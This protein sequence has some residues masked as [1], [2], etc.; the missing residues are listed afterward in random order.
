MVCVLVMVLWWVGYLADML[1]AAGCVVARPRL[2]W[3]GAR[4]LDWTSLR[5]T[6]STP[7]PVTLIGGGGHALVVAEAIGQGA[8]LVGFYDDDPAAKL[9]G[10]AQVPCLGSLAEIPAAL[11]PWFM[12]G[13]GDLGLR[14]RVL[15][16]LG[17]ARSFAIT[18]RTAFVSANAAIGTGVFV[19]PHAVVHTFAKVRDHAIINTGAIVEHECEIGENAHI[20]PGAVLGGNVMVGAD[21]LV[22]IG[23]RVIPGVRIGRGCVV[24]AGATVIRDVADGAKVVGVPARAY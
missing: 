1:L 8:V 23:A 5:M 20:A 15:G 4:W 24:G 6:E 19:G 16:A 13:L 9:G 10:A 7:R 22:G 18:H 3:T 2:A 17:R 21:T 12:L 11:E 14:R